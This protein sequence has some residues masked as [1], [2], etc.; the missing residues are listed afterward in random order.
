MSDLLSQGQ[1]ALKAGDKPKA[2]QLLQSAVQQNPQN[3]TAWLWLAGAVDSDFERA[4]Y[5]EKAL[6]INPGNAGARKELDRIR[7]A[8]PSTTPAPAIVPMPKF[9]K[10]KKRSPLIAIGIVLLGVMLI[11]GGLVGWYY[12][13]GPCGKVSVDRSTQKLDDLYSRWIDVNNLAAST[14]RIALSGPIATMQSIRQETENTKVPGCLVDSRD[15]LALAM[16]WSIKGYLAFAGQETDATITRYFSNSTSD[17]SA[18]RSKVEFVK[19]CAPFC[20]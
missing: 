17:F 11:T 9:R 14:S 3:E 13:L 19:I 2:R 6:A 10:R 7:A 20:K 15:F 5:L 12:F 18:Y 16:D 8:Q 1:A 4:M